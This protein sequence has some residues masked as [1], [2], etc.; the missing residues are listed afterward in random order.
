M[1]ACQP[2]LRLLLLLGVAD[3]CA[4]DPA[5]RVSVNVD[6]VVV[7][8]S[9][10]DQDGKIVSHLRQ[11]DFEVYEAGVR[12]TITL[13]QNE[14]IPVTAALVVDHSRSMV[15]KLPGVAVAVRAFVKASSQ[16]D[17]MFVVNFSDHPSFGLPEA[18]AFTNHASDLQ[19]AVEHNPAPGMTALYDGIALAH[20]H[21]QTG[22]RDKKVLLLVSDG[23]DNAS[24]YKLPEVLKLIQQSGVLLYAVGLFAVEDPDANP[25]VLRRLAHAS[26]GE[27]YFPAQVADVATVCEGIAYD[28]RHQY[29]IGYQPDKVRPGVYRSIRVAASDEGH[30]KLS[31]RARAGYVAGGHGKDNQ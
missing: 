2:A 3:A 21:L 10:R 13:F 14:D 19:L 15:A 27:A 29:T 24:H 9:V 4:Q 20:A 12:Q 31:V 25:G 28:I 26:G 1:R 6:L 8:A 22:S 11:E 30:R 23:S 17:E 5:F 7:H 18:M 16:Q